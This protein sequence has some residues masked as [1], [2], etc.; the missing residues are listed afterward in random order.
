M[1]TR[2]KRTTTKKRSPVRRRTPQKT[3]RRYSGRRKSTKMTGPISYAIS[4]VAYRMASKFISDKVSTYLTDFLNLFKDKEQAEKD[5]KLY[6]LIIAFGLM[7][8]VE[9]VKSLQKIPKIVEV[10]K[11]MFYVAIADYAGKSMGLYGGMTVTPS[12]RPV[13]RGAN[14]RY[15]GITPR[16]LGGDMPKSYAGMSV[17]Y[18][19]KREMP[20]EY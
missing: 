8:L 13:V 7:K 10:S 6:N 12:L 19:A 5:E 3:V 18:G 15:S 9:Y 4:I 1:A 20:L 17:K 11:F 16:K 2:K 14:K